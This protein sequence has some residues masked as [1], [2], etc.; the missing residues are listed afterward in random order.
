[1]RAS[2]RVYKK[3]YKSVWLRIFGM[4]RHLVADIYVKRISATLIEHSVVCSFVGLL[5]GDGAMV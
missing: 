3:E 2:I 4:V 5:T 1:M